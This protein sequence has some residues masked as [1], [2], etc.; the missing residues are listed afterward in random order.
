M[1]EHVSVNHLAVFIAAIVYF[2][3]GAIWYSPYLFRNFQ[4]KKE[5]WL[6]KRKGLEEAG[7]YI[8]EFILDLIMAYVL[9]LFIKEHP[10]DSIWDGIGKA[11]W[12]WVGFVFTTHLS[13]TIWGH[14]SWSHFVVHAV[15]ML[16]GLILMGAIIAAY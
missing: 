10:V 9:A 15:F 16:I 12:V 3:L 11:I 14:K 7:G 8:G 2:I 13:A 6:P 5:A 1:F 4:L